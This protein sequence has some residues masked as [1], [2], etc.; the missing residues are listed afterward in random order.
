MDP[1]RWPLAP[2]ARVLAQHKSEQHVH[3]A[4]GGWKLI[5]GM[6]TAATLIFTSGC[7]KTDWIDR[8]LVT[9]DVTGT[10][11]GIVGGSASGGRS[12]VDLYLEL[13]QKG[14][15]V[16][17]FVQ[18]IPDVATKSSGPVEGTVARLPGSGQEPWWS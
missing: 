11:N 8:T 17:G 2:Y 4:A 15:T 9:V 14:S 3:Q 16:K 6:L 18:M 1:T 7:A 12:S 13:E 5:A 10:W